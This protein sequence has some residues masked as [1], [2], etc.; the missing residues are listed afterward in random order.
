MSDVSANAPATEQTGVVNP[1]DAIA[2]M[3]DANR[4]RTNVQ[5]EGSTAPPAG[6]EEVKTESPEA[7]PEEV[8]EPED[9]SVETEE[10][11][12]SEVAEEPTE[13]VSEDAINFLEFAKSNPD[14]IWRIPN[15]DAEGGFLEV[16]V[17]KAAAILGQGSAIHEHARRLKAEKA[18]FEEYEA[19]RR[20]EIDGLQIGLELTIVPQLQSAADE[21]ITLQ[22]YNQQWQQILNSTSDEVKKAEAQAAI[23]QN[24]E[25]IQEKAEF[26]KANRPR[27]EEF[28]AQRSAEVQQRLEQA[29][30]SFKDKELSNKANFNEIREKLEKDW[31]NAK[32]SFVPGV[33]NIDLVSSDEH[34]MSLIRDGLK[35]REGPK[36]VK[37]AGGSLAA[38]TKAVSKAKTAPKDEASELQERAAKG[39]KGATRDL[40][41]QQLMAFKQRRR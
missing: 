19:N 14:M 21:L 36:V 6:Q 40:L 35:F 37:N 15:K 26:L 8:A 20:K 28:Y 11:A 34:L 39:D 12:N 29:R 9:S 31:G 16:P 24:A 7:A 33:P 22:G 3:I 1:A 32:S 2:A 18:E 4:Q 17:S 13:G 10:S 41:A 23:R 25:L 30:Q 27:V 5:P 38:T